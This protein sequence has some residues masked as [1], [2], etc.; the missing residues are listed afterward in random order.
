MEKKMLAK[1]SVKKPYTVIVTVILVI[2][3]GVV[4]FTEMTPDLLPSINLPYAVV[5]TSYTGAS[6]EEVEL[7]VTKPV[8]QAMA[9][10]N[11]IEHIT[12]TSSENVSMVILEFS[13]SANMDAITV[14][15]RES[16]DTISSYWDDSIGN[17]MIMKLNPDMLPVMVAAVDADDMSTVEVSKLANEKI[18]PQ[19]ESVEGVASVSVTGL[20][21]ENINVVIRQDKIDKINEKLQRSVKKELNKAE[22]KLENAKEKLKDG[23]QEL[24]NKQQEFNDGMLSASQG[25]LQGRLELLKGEIELANGEKELAQKESELKAAEKE[26][27]TGEKEAAAAKKTL[28]KSEKEA[29]T[30]L[31]KLKASLKQL[32]KQKAEAVTGKTTIETT[33]AI[34][35][36]NTILSETEK[37]TLLTPLQTQLTEVEKGLATLEKAIEELTTQKE[38]V[39]DGLKEITTG[40]KTLA[41]TQ[42]QLQTGKKQL[43]AGKKALALA[44]EKIKKAQ[45]GLE[46]GKNTLNEKESEIDQTKNKVGTELN[47]A[48]VEIQAGQKELDTQLNNFKDTKENAIEAADVTDKITADM[49]TNILK[50]QNFSMPAGYIQEEGE[51]YLVRV[52]D[53]IE[54]VAELKEL[55]LFDPKTDNMDPITLADVADVFWKDNADET[56]AKIN[57]NQG[58]MLSIQK[59]TNYSTADVTERLHKKFDSIAKQNSGVHMST[60]MDQ[61][62]YIDLVVDAVLNNLILGA[63]LAI[64]I[65]L[66]FLRDIRPTI[67]IACS[68]PI[69]VITAIVLMYFSGITLNII[70]LSGLAVGVGMLVDNSVVVIENIYRLRN[71]GVS[72]IKAAVTGAVQVGGAIIAS[73]LT[74]IAVFLPIVFVK[75]ITKQLFVDMALTIAYSLLASLIV[76]LSFVPMMSAKVLKNTKE[77]KHNVFNGFLRGYEWLVKGALKLKPVVLIGAVLLLVF[78]IWGASRNGTAFMP[79]MDST[80]VTVSMSM[81]DETQL[82]DTI[83]MSDT[84]VERIEQLEDVETVG[85]MLGGSSMLGVSSGNNAT[86]KVD[87]YVLLKENKKASGIEIAKEIEEMCADLDCTVT[88]TGSDMDMS[89]LG[90][91]GISINIKGNDLDTLKE[92]AKDVA[93]KL[94]TVKGVTDVND[95]MGEA[96]PEL[97]ITVDKEK[98]MLKGLTVAQ[99]YSEIQKELSSDT[100]ASNLMKEGKEYSIII[101]DEEA[102]NINKKDIQSYTFQTTDKD[103]KERKTKLKNIADITETFS[104][105][106]INRMGQERYITVSGAIEDGYNIG[107]VSTE[108]NKLFKTYQAP[109]GCEIEFSGENETI[110]EAMWQMIKML[111]LAVAFIY[112]IMVAQF[113]SLLSPFIVMFTIPLAFTGGFLGLLFTGKEVSIIAALGFVMLSGIVVNNG[114]VLVDY[115]N[116]L[117]LAGMEK[118]EA[119]VEAGITRMRPIFMTALTTV[120]GL[121][122]MAMGMGTG[123]DMMQPI[124]IVT[125]GGLLY[126]TLTTLFIIPIIYDIF[127]R[128]ELKAIDKA[129]LEILEEDEM[130]F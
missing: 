92:T 33:M 2:I 72:P 23:K 7:M 119:I 4:S 17:P 62:M 10:I 97:R 104:L 115:I 83:A 26:I 22:E 76:A 13:D 106:S 122:T 90:G 41:A 108:V 51:D 79:S 120:L 39:E 45:P 32:E 88:A 50:A 36:N 49:I 30:G 38:T 28:E 40:K 64:I 56:Y 61:G 124:A 15:I 66:L 11:N 73:T 68:I 43:T 25:I 58:V 54:D 65:L 130:I 129:E 8:E 85:A 16:L 1:F 42:K 46:Q 71:K 57:G 12:S 111:L 121:S 105:S 89:A 96:T 118:K 24:A 101:V 109:S 59:Q 35:K 80:Q 99:V 87:I 67:V 91:S 94:K 113:Q 55:V 70:S 112:L 29:N 47:N 21:E 48:S 44:K 37:A 93:E 95:G 63:I 86:D 127:N 100:T 6:P 53:K 3:L 84:I 117:R 14:D 107:L 52:G 18:I 114:I 125:I 110:N 34:V 102:E 31:T 19:V 20:V 27:E 128:K 60:L 123:A 126:A 116:Q 78:S 74:T 69:S 103:G 81:P 77:K 98:A 75:G 5:M 82:E 9:T